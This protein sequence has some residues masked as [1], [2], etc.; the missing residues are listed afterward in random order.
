MKV[1]I[2]GSGTSTGVPVIGCGCAVCQSTNHKNFRS[3]ASVAIEHKGHWYV[4]DTGPDFRTQVLKARIEKLGAVFY[5]HT[6]ADH[7]HGFDDLRAFSFYSSDAIPCYL[8]PEH[9]ED[10]KNRFSYAFVETGYKGAKPLASLK[11]IPNTPFLVDDLEIEPVR[12]QHGH[13]ITCGFRIG[14]FAY[15]TDFKGFPSDKLL[16]WKGK[17]HTLVASGIHF[18]DHPSHNNIPETCDLFKELGVERGIL[19]HLSHRVDYVSDAGRL[20]QGVEFAYDGM[21]V[22]V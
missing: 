11:L 16:S 6:H 14:G 17:I 5:T 19:T 4:I 3:R 21:Q 7:C 15:L 1:V 20:P 12:L 8:L 22:D 18:G 9:I 2:L 10:F 13:M